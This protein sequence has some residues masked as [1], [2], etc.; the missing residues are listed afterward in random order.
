MHGFARS[1]IPVRVGPP[2]NSPFSVEN[3]GILLERAYNGPEL[4]GP[5]SQ[6][7][8]E[9]RSSV[10][11]RDINASTGQDDIDHAMVETTSGTGPGEDPTRVI[12]LQ[13]DDLDNL[14]KEDKNVLFRCPGGNDTFPIS[15]DARRTHV[16]EL[17]TAIYN[18]VDTI[19][20]MDGPVFKKRWA[21]GA[22]YY[23]TVMIERQ[24]WRVLGDVIDL[25]QNGW[26]YRIE[27]PL[28]WESIQK[29]KDLT[30]Q[31]RW[32]SIVRLLTKSKRRCDDLMKR[33]KTWNVIGQAGVLAPRT[34]TNKRSNDRKGADLKKVRE[35][36]EA[37]G[38]K[39]QD[40]ATEKNKKKATASKTKQAKKQNDCGKTANP[41]EDLSGLPAAGGEFKGEQS[42]QPQMARLAPLSPAVTS[43][44]LSRVV[45]TQPDLTPCAAA[46]NL[47]EPLGPGHIN[48]GA[49]H[50]PTQGFDMDSIGSRPSNLPSINHEIA[51]PDPRLSQKRSRDEVNDNEH[52]ES[53]ICPAPAD[54]AAPARPVKRARRTNN[55]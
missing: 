27:D 29:S 54:T 37:A 50:Q 9:P 41:V 5:S 42:Q 26:T 48:T 49:Y 52:T 53:A 11:N 35:E 18:N 33:E 24:A 31:E 7:A 22:K 3:V 46:P 20:S 16:T 51:S 43:T 55:M 8:V 21:D 38:T 23:D 4:T 12:E 25:H 40:D 47:R 15:R 45:D 10:H 32:E 2:F 1:R 36:R 44:T 34:I 19:E 39:N 6:H 30:F 28:L 17:I 13:Y 14:Q